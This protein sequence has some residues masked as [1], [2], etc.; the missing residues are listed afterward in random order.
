VR[1]DSAVPF[2][3]HGLQTMIFDL[4][5][6]PR[7]VRAL[8][9]FGCCGLFV[10]DCT[11]VEAQTPGPITIDEPWVDA[12]GSMIESDWQQAVASLQSQIDALNRGDEEASICCVPEPAAKPTFPNVRLSGFFQADSLW[13][14][15]SLENQIA[16][17]NGIAADGDVKTVPIFVAPDWRQLDKLGTMS[18]TCWKWILHSPDAQVLWTFGWK[19]TTWSGQATFASDSF[20]NRLGWTD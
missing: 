4:F 15:Q 14:S 8:I 19:W 6:L 17:G 16:V 12:S 5:F 2:L 9:L 3:F 1:A 10:S 18:P 20:G 11:A 13:A 7:W